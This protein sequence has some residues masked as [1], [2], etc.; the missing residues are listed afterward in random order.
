MLI[1]HC[2]QFQINKDT[3]VHSLINMVS[4]FAA[5]QNTSEVIRA[6]LVII[7]SEIAYNV[8]KFANQAQLDLQLVENKLVITCAE[9]SNGFSIPLENAFIEGVSTAGSLGLGMGSM[10]RMCDD[11]RLCTNDQGTTIVCTKEL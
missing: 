11:F 2:K 1:M 6:E 5:Q 4:Y 3:D 9:Q 8:I 10:I 7:C